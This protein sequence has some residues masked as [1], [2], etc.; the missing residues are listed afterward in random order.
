[1][2]GKER[3]M[4][5]SL[6][7]FDLDG[8][9]IDSVGD[10]AWGANRTLSAL[11]RPEMTTGE[12]KASVGSGVKVLLE[13]LMPGETTGVIEDA[14][15]RFLAFYATHLV[16]ETRVYPGVVETLDHFRGL[17]KT[18]AIVTNKPES[19][20]REITRLLGFS[21]RFAM[22]VG[23]DTF[24]NRKPHP[25][26]LESVLSS[27]GASREAAVFI[28][29]SAIDLETGR[30]AGVSTIGVS[31][32]FNGGRRELEEAGFDVVIDAFPELKSVV[33]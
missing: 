13:R 28:G 30:S 4:E 10:I 1:M 9:L 18:L 25:E 23:G 27:L 11:G 17:G 21:D 7:V 6:M 20:A 22:L 31:Y 16:D 19:F 32:G 5:K 12:I 29:D 2:F 15:K 14:R 3:A 33:T 26:P 8:T 24:A